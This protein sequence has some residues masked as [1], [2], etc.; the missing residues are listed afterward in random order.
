MQVTTGEEQETAKR[1][2]ERIDGVR[3]ILPMRELFEKRLG[4]WQTVTRVMLS[5][6]VFCAFPEQTDGT[7]IWHGVRRTDG[8][9]RILGE[10]LPP[11][12]ERLTTLAN[13]GEVWRV[14]RCRVT[15]GR[16]C[17]YDG[18]LK[19]HEDWVTGFDRHRRR[20]Q[21]EIHIGDEFHRIQLGLIQD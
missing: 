15:D 9:L 7:A 21:V 16:L 14:S 11:D 13:G 20:A 10:M 5:G 12:M 3:I 18:P 17:I 6:Y 1:I 2:C 8:V 19:G 4:G